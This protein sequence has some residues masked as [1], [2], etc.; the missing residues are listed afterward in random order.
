M[1]KFSCRP[2]LSFLLGLYLAVELL[3]HM[4]A[5]HLAVWLLCFRSNVC[6]P[7]QDCKFLEI[8]KLIYI[9]FLMSSIDFMWLWAFY[10][11]TARH[12]TS[13]GLSFLLCKM[14][15]II[16]INLWGLLWAL[17]ERIHGKCIG[18]CIP[19]SKSWINVGTFSLLGLNYWLSFFFNK[20]F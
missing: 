10:C 13:L 14:G 16:I 5:L 7:K 2:V 11:A 17:N 18:Q 8:K 3:N 20:S 12:F 1:Y 6:F 15:V 9:Y 19:Y 4:V